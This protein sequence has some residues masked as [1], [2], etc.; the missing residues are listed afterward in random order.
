MK[1]LYLYTK[2]E[3]RING[4]IQEPMT[5]GE[6]RALYVDNERVATVRAILHPSDGKSCSGCYLKSIRETTKWCM[7]PIAREGDAVLGS[8]CCSYSCILKDIEEILENL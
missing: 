4:P 2:S 3:D 6:I 7:I 1:G 8:T 5:K